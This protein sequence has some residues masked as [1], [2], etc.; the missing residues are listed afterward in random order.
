MLRSACR[1]KPVVARGSGAGEHS[2]I[3]T[4]G[5]SSERLKTYQERTGPKTFTENKIS[6]CSGFLIKWLG[7]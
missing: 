2:W 5:N 3:E 7:V 6:L 4:L 1:L